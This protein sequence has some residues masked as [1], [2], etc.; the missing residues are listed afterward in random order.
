MVLLHRTVDFFYVYCSLPGHLISPVVFS[1]VGE[2]MRKVEN[3]FQ[4]HIGKI[5]SSSTIWNIYADDA[6]LRA[7]SK[8][9]LTIVTETSERQD[10]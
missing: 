9:E 2:I 6:T 10:K 3:K 5:V 8:D 1:T 7:R 4:S